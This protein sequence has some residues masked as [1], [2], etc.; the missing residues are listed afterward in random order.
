MVN[1][2]KY[3]LISLDDEK[4]KAISEV[5]GS[6][7]CKKM[8]NHLAENKE[9]SQKDLSDALKIPMNTIEYNIKKLLDSGF[10]QKRKNFFWSKKGKKII[11]YELSNKSIIISHK[12][13]V[14]NKIKSITPAFILTAVGTF[15]LWVYQRI[16]SL[17]NITRNSVV[18]DTLYKVA[19]ESAGSSFSTPP[20]AL[21]TPIGTPLWLWFLVGALIAIFVISIVNWR[22]L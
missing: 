19:T 3:M 8:I 7:T 12:K 6:S 22:K 2:S 20:E 13:S 21:I 4:S 17:S 10:I 1:E 16:N 5:L 14:Y 18:D 15:S 9:A 11:M